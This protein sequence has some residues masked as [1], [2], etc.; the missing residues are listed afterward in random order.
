MTAG[1]GLFAYLYHLE[2]HVKFSPSL[3][4]TRSFHGA[5]AS[6]HDG[7]SNLRQLLHV[8]RGSGAK[9]HLEVNEFLLDNCNKS[10]F[11][12]ENCKAERTDSS[13]SILQQESDLSCN[14][15]CAIH[16]NVALK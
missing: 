5:A 15:E 9:Q 11:L 4:P 1:D 12:I 13:L 10:V 16:S 2:S 6:K 3:Y 14:L 8:F 7:E